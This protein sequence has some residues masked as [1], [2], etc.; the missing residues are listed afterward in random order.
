MPSTWAVLWVLALMTSVVLL[1]A[2]LPGVQPNSRLSFTPTVAPFG[3][4]A[5]SAMT[6]VFVTGLYVPCTGCGLSGSVTSTPPSHVTAA[7]FALALPPA[8]LLPIHG[9]H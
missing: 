7:A 6:P 9:T 3:P 4:Q 1:F 2:L 5:V 8:A